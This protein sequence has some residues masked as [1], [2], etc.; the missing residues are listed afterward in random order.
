MRSTTILTAACIFAIVLAVCVSAQSPAPR[1]SA[2]PTAAQLPPVLQTCPM[3]PDV[4]EDK[5]GSCPLCRMALVPVRLESVWSCPLH[6]A[7]TKSGKGVCP[8]CGRE[9][10]QMTMALTWTCK[11]RPDI[12]VIEP[13]RCPDGSLMIA[14]RTL[15]P[16]GNHNPQH[17]GQFFMAPDNT[18]HLEGTLPSTR[19]FR[20][21]LYDDYARPLTP[22]R[23]K[24][25]RGRVE[26]G[27]RSIPLTAAAAGSYL[28]ARLDGIA[29]PARMTA[30]LQIKPDAPEY[31]FDFAFPALTRDPTPPTVSR[32][33]EA[34]RPAA[35][36]IPA[37]SGPAAAA[38]SSIDPALIQVPI[39]E[40]V[41][42]ILVQLRT[43][44]RQVRE[45]I[46]RGNLAAVFV[47]AFQ[48]RD[49]AIAL[50]PRLATLAASRDATGAA[51]VQLVR[52]AWTLDAAGDTGNRE[53][54][55][56]A[57]TVFHQAAVAIDAAFAARR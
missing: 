55:T 26:I 2:T 52:A 56:A 37:S 40:T 45:L 43:R 4:V 31:R 13:A 9:L 34:P 14:K 16:H 19:L 5:P 7:I 6:A 10:V 28:D 8:I 27:G 12:D 11:G 41:P 30:R 47:P 33:R 22:V 38:D 23:L 42:D 54:A 49:L 3:H 15:R 44:D 17:G 50:E 21:Y 57:Y 39:P 51:I 18:H 32:P 24:P 53:Q 35:P 29:L 20:V 36:T 25:V 1:A 46:D 48:A